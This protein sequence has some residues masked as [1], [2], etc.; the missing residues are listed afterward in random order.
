MAYPNFTPEEY[1]EVLRS[2]P[3]YY[4]KV[5]MDR[6]HGHYRAVEQ[7]SFNDPEMRQYAAN[8]AEGIERRFKE[9]ELLALIGGD[10]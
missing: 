9:L 4:S 3:E 7:T 1:C 2:N 6:L 10:V 8:R 5:F